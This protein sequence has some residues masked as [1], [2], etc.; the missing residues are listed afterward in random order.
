MLETQLIGRDEM[1]LE[2]RN[3][4]KYFRIIVL[5]FYNKIK[6]QYGL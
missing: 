4:N 2:Q 1:N 5:D 6:W 3:G